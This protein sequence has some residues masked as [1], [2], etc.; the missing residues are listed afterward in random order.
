MQSLLARAEREGRIDRVEDELF[1]FERIVAGNPGCGTP[2]PSRK[3]DASGKEALVHDLLEGKAAPETMRLTEQAVR[4]PGVAA[5]TGSSRTISTWRPDPARGAHRAGPT[6]ACSAPSSSTRGSRGASP[7]TTGSRSP[8]RSS[9]DPA[10]MGGIRVQVGDEVVDG[11]VLRRLEGG[12][13]ARHRRLDRHPALETTNP[14]APP[15]HSTSAPRGPAT[16]EK[17]RP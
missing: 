2:S 13:S 3:T 1:R 12:P 9:V 14:D 16:E 11:T 5:S 10:V 17:I 4:S 7:A 15:D 6:V 8:S